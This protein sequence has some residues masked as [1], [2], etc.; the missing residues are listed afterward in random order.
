LIDDTYNYNL[1]AASSRQRNLLKDYVDLRI[2]Q[3]NLLILSLQQNH[4]RDVENDLKAVSQK[5]KEKI[6][7]LQKK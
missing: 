5:V 2:Q 4:D 3:T 7:E 1:D 6:E